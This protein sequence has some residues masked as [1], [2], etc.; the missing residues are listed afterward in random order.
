SLRHARRV[1]TVK[2]I[3]QERL[4]QALNK[5]RKVTQAQLATLARNSGPQGRCHICARN[6][7]YLELISVDDVFFFPADQRYITARS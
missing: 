6:R 2:L 4:E 5:A 7:G 1:G 3:R